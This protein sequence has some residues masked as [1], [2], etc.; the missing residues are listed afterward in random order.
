[1]WYRPLGIL[2]VF[3]DI[4]VRPITC[5][6]EVCVNHQILSVLLSCQTQVFLFLSITTCFDCCVIPPAA[7]NYN[8]FGKPID[9][10]LKSILQIILHSLDALIIIKQ[11]LLLFALFHKN[12]IHVSLIVLFQ[13]PKLQRCAEGEKP[14]LLRLGEVIHLLTSVSKHTE[15]LLD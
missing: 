13:V 7:V 4:K 2:W 8:R 6:S 5:T 10:N 11:F 3:W 14:S 12:Q 1:M 9:L 15:E